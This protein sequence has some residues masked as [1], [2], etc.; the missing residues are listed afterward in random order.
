MKKTLLILALLSYAVAANAYIAIVGAVSNTPPG[1]TSGGW[2]YTV[3]VG[4][5]CLVLTAGNKGINTPPSPAAFNGIPLTLA[6]TISSLQTAYREVSIYYLYNPPVGTY[7]VTYDNS[8]FAANSINVISLAGVNTNVLPVSCTGSNELTGGLIAYAT[9]TNTPVNA[10]AVTMHADSVS[11]ITV[12]MAVTNLQGASSCA[13]TNQTVFYNDVADGMVCAQYA[14]SFISAGTNVFTSTMSANVGGY[15]NVLAVT[16]FAPAPS[17]YTWDGSTA[18][19]SIASH[20]GGVVPGANDTGLITNGIA[21]ATSGH[22]SLPGNPVIQ[23]NTGGTFDVQSGVTCTDNCI[24]VGGKLALDDSSARIGNISMVSDST[25]ALTWNPVFS[26]NSTIPC[27]IVGKGNLTVLAGTDYATTYTPVFYLNYGVLT[28][29]TGNITIKNPYSDLL[30]QAE[31]YGTDSPTGALNL[32]SYS[33]AAMNA[34]YYIDTP[35]TPQN[36]RY[37]TISGSGIVEVDWN[38]SSIFVGTNGIMNITPGGVGTVGNLGFFIAANSSATIPQFNAATT[39]RVQWN[40]DVLSPT[41]Y[42]QVEYGTV[43][44]TKTGNIYV[45]LTNMDL[46]VT[47][48]YAPGYNDII[49]VLKNDGPY[50]IIGTFTNLPEGAT[51]ALTSSVPNVAC[52]AQIT[53]KA[54]PNTNSA[55]LYGFRTTIYGNGTST[56]QIAT[57]LVMSYPA[58]VATWTS[59]VSGDWYSPFVWANHAYLGNSPSSVLN[60]FGNVPINNTA[61][62]AITDLPLVNT[63]NTLNLNGVLAY[64]NMIITFGGYT[65]KTES[66]YNF[67]ALIVFSNS[68]GFYSGFS[69][70]SGYDLRFTQTNS[71]TGGTVTNYTDS[72]GVNWNA[73]I[74]TNSGTFTMTTGGYVGVLV[75]AGGGGSAGINGTGAGG[76]GGAGGMITTNLY[77]PASGVFTVSVGAGGGGGPA[78]TAGTNGAN[79][80]FSN[81]FNSFVA[82]GG[83]GGGP[84]NFGIGSAG[85]SGGSGGGGSSAQ[86]GG[87]GVAGQGS[88]GGANYGYGGGASGTGQP[89]RVSNI[90]GSNVT[91]AS[92]GDNAFDATIYPGGGGRGDLTVDSGLATAGLPNTGGGGGARWGTTVA[93]KSGGSGI[94]IV[95]YPTTSTLNYEIESWNTNGLSYVWVDVGTVASNGTSQISASW[96]GPAAQQAYT[97]N[98]SVWNNNYLAVWHLGNTTDSTVRQYTTNASSYTATNGVID[99]AAYFAGGANQL[100]YG[101]LQAFNFTNT[102]P[103]SMECWFNASVWS[104]NPMIVGKNSN[105]GTFTGWGLDYNSGSLRWSL[106]NNAIASANDIVVNVTAPAVGNWMYYSVNMDGS[107]KAAGITLFTNGLSAAFSTFANSLSASMSNS[108]AF[109]IGNRDGTGQPFNGKVDEVRI[110]SVARSTNWVWATYQS[111]ASNGTFQVYAPVTTNIVSNVTVSLGTSGTL[112]TF[113]GSS[114]AINVNTVGNGTNAV[115]TAVNPGIAVANNL[116]ISGNGSASSKL[117]LGD[118]LTGTNSVTQSNS[119]S[120]ILGGRVVY[121]LASTNYYGRI[122]V[123]QGALNI[124]NAVLSL[125]DTGYS[126]LLNDTF[127]L[128]ATNAGVG[129]CYG[130]FSNLAEGAAVATAG[131]T[132]KISYTNNVRLIHQ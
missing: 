68:P 23:V 132:Y 29:F 7:A 129:I 42:D 28:G 44:G 25:L 55:A 130:T 17:T 26:P 45:N 109:E 66:L 5:N 46:K 20:W 1:T 18:D 53:Y 48:R 95:R 94:V 24:L 47:M 69:S 64:T 120:V 63:L 103:W 101:N 119:C 92:G 41:N 15:K 65:N 106:V 73:H 104:G 125:S 57:T 67:P 88:A 117:T 21:Q 51:V 99:G 108:T 111:Q 38:K 84:M 81:S 78:G 11:G 12:S 121:T 126:G 35:G 80:A 97:T 122:S 39:T 90:V 33:V 71:G 76:A 62:V 6:T 31:F 89:G 118:I 107:S 105:S 85:N 72:N 61:P 102:V 34:N 52:T 32:V 116:L 123:A 113:A 43:N 93:G 56:N 82:I 83:G 124:S 4:A 128:I 54:G 30:M 110:S 50:P 115:S 91:Y 87:S 13:S 19:W 77:I 70:T 60:I 114:P 58:T 36:I 112:W 127:T 2:L 10:F 75:V 74:F 3:P 79:S 96:G 131:N 14:C 49:T 37:N 27:S 100:G 22:T 8:S 9:L 40:I 98:G 86:A 16:A 59:L